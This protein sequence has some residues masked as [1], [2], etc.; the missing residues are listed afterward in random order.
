MAEETTLAEVDAQKTEE[1]QDAVADF[2]FGQE[3][4]ETNEDYQPDPK[5]VV[6]GDESEVVEEP[7]DDEP[8]EAEFVEVE[9]EGQLYEV[10][11]NL[12]D[13]LLRQQDYTTKTQEVAQSRKEVEVQLGQVEQTRQQFA[14]AE[15]IQGDVIQAQQ[16]EREAEQL[17]EWMQN[18]V[19]TVS[20]TE[21]DQV[22]F[23]RDD[24]LKQR[25]DIVRSVQGKQSEF[26]QAQEQSYTELL[27]K[28]T[29]VLRQKI[30]GW[31]EKEQRQVRD[32][33]LS[34]GFTEAEISQ[35]VDPR[36]VELLYK[37]SQ[38]DSLKSGVTPAVKKVQEA[39]SIKP[40]ARDPKTGKFVA[41]QNLQKKLKSNNISQSEKASLIG[42]DIAGKFF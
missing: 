23:R 13:A 37:A 36:H 20:S 6:E 25:D 31:G 21:L 28:G 14:F 26:Q 17:Y 11:N 35:V 18:N 7:T 41:K 32:Y 12:K 8:K 24:L 34:S 42:D 1:A 9:F 30:P 27:N 29:E 19:G 38:Y 33:A 2:L 3:P 5:P 22:R 4:E 40:K 10:P 15:S 39:P 16:F